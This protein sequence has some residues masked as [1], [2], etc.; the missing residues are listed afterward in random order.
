MWQIQSASE[1]RSSV[2]TPQKAIIFC[3][4]MIHCYSNNS[5]WNSSLSATWPSVCYH[6]CSATCAEM[7]D[8]STPPPT[9]KCLYV[10]FILKRNLS[11][12]LINTLIVFSN[13][14]AVCPP[15]H[16]E[17]MEISRS[18]VERQLLNTPWI[19]FVC[20]AFKTIMQSGFY[21]IKHPGAILTNQ[22]G[23]KPDR[24]WST[25]CS[26]PPYVWPD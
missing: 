10:D 3:I 17:K 22:I 18:T 16:F 24:D 15:V 19:L 4:F 6:C 14:K 7:K 26:T 13:S 1:I 20:E 5:T 8:F 11:N 2:S 12:V 9:S 25:L 21:I 23:L